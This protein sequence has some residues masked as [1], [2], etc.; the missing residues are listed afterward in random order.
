METQN[1]TRKTFRDNY[2]FNFP[3]HEQIDGAIKTFIE[4]ALSVAGGYTVIYNDP[5]NGGGWR[6]P[7]GIIIT[8]PVV[9]FRV[10]GDFDK[11]EHSILLQ[12]FH[13]LL[14]DLGEHSSFYSLNG[15]ATIQEL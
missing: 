13:G 11:P 15:Y 7:S 10:S 4:I 5:R 3:E 8:E 6:D 9:V 1:R 14:K 12:E 2:Y